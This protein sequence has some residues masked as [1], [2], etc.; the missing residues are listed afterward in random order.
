MQ[1]RTVDLPEPEGPKITAWLPL[2]ICKSITCKTS[3]IPK[4]FRTP[5]SSI[6]TSLFELVGTRG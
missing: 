1:R 4:V 5:E 2:V 3:I 6:R